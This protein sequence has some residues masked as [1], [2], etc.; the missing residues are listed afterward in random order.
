MSTRTI[1]LSTVVDMGVGLSVARVALPLVLTWLANLGARKVPGYHASVRRVSLD[2][3]T[4][5]LSVAGLSLVKLNGEHSLQLNSLVIG[6]RWRDLLLRRSLIAY[7]KVD[8]PRVILDVHRPKHASAQSGE[9]KTNRQL[10]ARGKPPWL[11]KVM[12]LPAFRISPAALID[13]ELH[14]LGIPGQN[15]TDIRIDRLNLSFDNI[16][17]SLTVAPTLMAKAACSARVMSAANLTFD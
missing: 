11:A 15:G 13:G 14:L 17:N 2:V 16:T 7:L 10:E 12:S 8:S 4:P 5:R 9:V 1:R 6:S 3:M